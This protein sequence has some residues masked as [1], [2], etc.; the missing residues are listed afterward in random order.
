MLTLLVLAAAA[1]VGGCAREG[2]SSSARDSPPD[3]LDAPAAAGDSAAARDAAAASDSAASRDSAVVRSAPRTRAAAR[4][5]PLAD[6]ISS[7]IV[8]VARDQRWFLAAVR[9]GRLLLDLGRVDVPV[10]TPPRLTA[11]RDA[12]GSF[13]PLRVDDHL[14]LAGSW[15][16]VAAT[17]T[18]YD[19]WNGRVVATLDVPP[20]VDSAL[21][22]G[23]AAAGASPGLAPGAAARG[24]PPQRVAAAVRADGDSAAA[25]A[26]PAA[27]GPGAAPA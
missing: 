23:S 16:T 18:G 12:A 6:S 19:V 13:A 5:G 20:A 25:G 2:R 27:N 7:R 24:E 10:K 8:W 14:R 1:A 17:V 4:L 21:G 15:G 3:S 11:L 9:G 22:V 26:V